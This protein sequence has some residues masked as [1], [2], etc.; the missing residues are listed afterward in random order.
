[1]RPPV[2]RVHHE[3]LI[4]DSFAGGGGA[5]T[6]IERATGRSPD[7][8]INHNGDA[9]ALHQVN[10]PNTR[11]LLADVFSVNPREVCGG[12]QVALFWASPDCTFHSRARGGKPF[13]D[14]NKARRRRG[15]AGVI[16]KWA[17]Q[18]R[19]RVICAENV[20]EFAFWG[21]LD[22]E[23]RPDPEKRGS[24]FQRWVAQLRNLGYQVEWR[25]LRAC[26]YGAPTIRKRLFVI[27]RCDGEPIVWPEVTH[28]P[29]RPLPYRAAAECIQWEL[30]CPSIFERKKPLAEKTLARIARGLL[31]FVIEDPSPFL[32][33]VT[34]QG[35]HR[36]YP[37]DEP[38]RTVTA[39]RRGEFALISPQLVQSGYGER[40]GQAPRALDIREPIGTLVAGGVKHRLVAAFLAK[41]FGDPGRT[42][43]GGVVL[44]APLQAP[45]GTVT[46]RDHHALVT[47]H[48]V[49]YRGTCKDG[50]RMDEPAPTLTAG[51]TH[52]GEVRAFLQRYNGVG[53]G[54]PLQLSLGTVTTKDRFGL[55]TVQGVG[56]QVVDIGSRMLVARELFRAQSFEDS[57]VIDR[58]PDGSQLTKETQI[59]LCG[60]SVPPAVVEAIVR[61]N[62]AR[63]R[64]VAA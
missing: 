56:Y 12:R 32:V 43:G 63:V 61:A 38:M 37:I 22:D 33:P 47:S 48:M 53:I 26:D 42:S 5:S 35:D 4:V 50:R 3:D 14:R 11:H 27:A 21:P 58:R 13:R 40:D 36:I 17:A 16:V 34:H 2:V 18:V 7:L 49:V 55:V 19:P 6:G 46:C 60:N 25:T 64:R 1:M 28:G 59:A 30:A 24:S 54:Q 8:A 51:G 10:H 44:G 57:Y 20:E 45:M 41:H 9:L 15:L 62:L 29:G 39:A 23:G 52:L 31:R